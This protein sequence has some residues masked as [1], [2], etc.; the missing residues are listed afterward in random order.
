MR[1]QSVSVLEA[2][3]EECEIFSLAYHSAK[4]LHK[5]KH[6]TIVML[7]QLLSHRNFITMVRL[8]VCLCVCVCVF[9]CVCVSES[10]TDRQ[11][12]RQREYVCV[13]VCVRACVCMRVSVCVCLCLC[14][15]ISIHPYVSFLSCVW[16]S[17]CFFFCKFMYTV[18]LNYKKCGQ[19]RIIAIIVIGSN[20]DN[21]IYVYSYVT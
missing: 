8:C 10:K 11:T 2:S 5:F 13:C 12:E 6:A 9:A 14:L 3:R 19:I 18:G 20:S 15:C 16:E 4:Q 1:R 17:W 21:G 7:H